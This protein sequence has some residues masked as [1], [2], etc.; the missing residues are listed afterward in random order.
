MIPFVATGLT[1]LRA[2]K[3]PCLILALSGLVAG[4]VAGYKLASAIGSG[5]VAR[6]ELALSNFRAELA[7][8]TA[9]AEATGAE[10]QRAAMAALQQRDAATSEAVAAIPAQV[11]AMLAPRFTQLR[12]SLNAPTYDCLRVP[13]PA[14]ALGLLER[15]GGIAPATR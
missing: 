11:A 2:F 1:W 8:A 7:A 9:T 15:P 6:A 10:R 14:D 4:G 5:R 12:E 3:G 13:M